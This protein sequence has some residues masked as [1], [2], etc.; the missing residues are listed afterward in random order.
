V[1]VNTVFKINK[2]IRLRVQHFL[3]NITEF[4]NESLTRLTF[5]GI[6]M[7]LKDLIPF[8]RKAKNN[9]D[10]LTIK[11][12]LT[13]LNFTRLLSTQPE[14]NISTIINDVSVN[15]EEVLE[16]NFPIEIL[17]GFIK[18]LRRNTPKKRYKNI[19]INRKIDTQ[20]VTYHASQKKG[21]SGQ[22]ALYSCLQDVNNLPS[23]LLDSILIVGGAKLRENVNLVK[24]NLES[25]SEITKQPYSEKSAIRK[26]SYFP[27]KEGKT[28]VIAIGDY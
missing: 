19:W 27:D 9:N 18:F 14:P 3:A 2:D 1:G 20:F 10:K 13:V 28:R 11:L 15:V 25:L 8:L 26:L 17:S 16:E 22:A 7:I 4:R 23:S 24:E 12:I 21:P 5:D 6:P